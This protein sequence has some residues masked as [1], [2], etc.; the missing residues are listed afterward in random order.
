MIPLAH[1]PSVS[2]TLIPMVDCCV[3]GHHTMIIRH[4]TSFDANMHDGPPWIPWAWLSIG[5]PP[6]NLISKHHEWPCSVLHL[7][8]PWCL[9]LL[10]SPSWSLLSLTFV[11]HTPNPFLHCNMCHY[12]QNWRSIP[13]FDIMWIHLLSFTETCVSHNCYK[14]YYSTTI[15]TSNP[16]IFATSDAIFITRNLFYS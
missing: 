6:N 9:C 8:P 1:C 3:F 5:C 14:N 13:I 10:S 2:I 7:V 4:Y 11:S 12:E 15:R 16:S